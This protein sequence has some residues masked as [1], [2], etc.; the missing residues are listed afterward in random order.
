MSDLTIPPELVTSHW[1]LVRS[2]DLCGL[3]ALFGSCRPLAA[4]PSKTSG[5][6]AVVEGVLTGYGYV[7]VIE[8]HTDVRCVASVFEGRMDVDTVCSKVVTGDSGCD[9]VGIVLSYGLLE[10][11][12]VCLG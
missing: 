11:W 4:I 1:W 10:G 12:L 5:D 2:V 6:T 3:D 8:Y 7:H 9:V